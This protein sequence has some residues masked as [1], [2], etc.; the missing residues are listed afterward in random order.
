MWLMVLLYV[1]G[2]LAI[3]IHVNFAKYNF[4]YD[5]FVT[6]GPCAMN[7]GVYNVHVFVPLVNQELLI[8]PKSIC[9]HP[10]F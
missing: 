3:S 9:I 10:R 4:L 8:L 6:K 7:L 5:D 1:Y 2:F